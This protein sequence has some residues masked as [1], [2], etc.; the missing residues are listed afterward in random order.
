MKTCMNN[1]SKLKWM[2][3]TEF[4]YKKSRTPMCSSKSSVCGLFKWAWTKWPWKVLAKMEFNLLK[5]NLKKRFCWS[6]RLKIK[7][8]R[9]KDN[10]IITSRSRTLTLGRKPHCMG[11]ESSQINQ[12]LGQPTKLLLVGA[13]VIP[14]DRVKTVMPGEMTWCEK[15][16]CHFSRKHS[17]SVCQMTP[18]WPDKTTTST[19]WKSNN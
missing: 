13:W 1:S 10:E 2:S 16:P 11:Q 12:H 4:K 18:P 19:S 6:L 7:L 5:T 8:R 14:V 9:K 17:N 3:I 15:A